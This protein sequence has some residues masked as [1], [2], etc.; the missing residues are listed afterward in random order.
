[1]ELVCVFSNIRFQRYNIGMELSKVSLGEHDRLLHDARRLWQHGAYPQARSVA[2]V[3]ILMT[4]PVALS[5]DDYD[6]L[7]DTGINPNT[8]AQ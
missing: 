6:F 8:S 3:M 1:M 4:E 2:D 5:V 7:H